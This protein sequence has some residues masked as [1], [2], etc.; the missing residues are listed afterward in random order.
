MPCACTF[1][2]C[3]SHNHWLT[4]LGP[5]VSQ[6]VSTFEHSRSMSLS[7]SLCRQHVTARNKRNRSPYAVCVAAYQTHK[8]H[9]LRIHGWSIWDREYRNMSTMSEHQIKVSRWLA[10][11]RSSAQSLSL[12]L[13]L[14]LSLSLSRSRK[15]QAQSLPVCRLCC[16]ISR[17]TSWAPMVGTSVT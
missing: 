16:N 10:P 7:L 3:V 9:K 11:I 8:A 17:H 5:C 2:G 15:Q 13:S 1:L 4:C 14:S 12:D 6:H